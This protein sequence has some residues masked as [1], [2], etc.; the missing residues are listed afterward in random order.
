MRSINM[1][2]PKSLPDFMRLFPDDAACTA[3]LEDLR[4]PD[5]FTCA[6]CGTVGEPYRFAAFPGRL[7]CRSCKKTAYL[8]AG[9]VMERSHT[10]L[11]VW[12]WGAYLVSSLTPGM[13][14]VQFQRQLGLTRYETA[15]QI[16]H[17][18]R[19]GMVDA[20]RTKLGPRS[21]HVEV[22]ET[23]VGGRE[24]GTGR[25]VHN[26]IL[27]VGAIEAR[28]RAPKADAIDE[29]HNKATPKRGGLYAGRLRLSVIPSRQGKY[30]QEFVRG[31]VD[32]GA[33]VVTDGWRGYAK[34]VNEYEHIA[35]VEGDDDARV[36]EEYLPLIHLIFS[37][38]KAWLN[39]VHH[40]VGA[41]HLQAYLNEF[42]FRFNRRFLPFNAFKSLLGIGAE[43]ESPTYAE[44][45]S[46]T[47]LHPNQ[48]AV[49]KVNPEDVIK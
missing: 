14:A 40:G 9:T 4:W 15:F 11:S 32:E 45:Y 1:P 19:A 43:S 3:Y 38:L 28:R 44:L 6:Y 7:R 34:L 48:V 5:G 30:L 13:S 2:F 25:G 17:K 20:D 18:L 35:A 24:R 42:V 27:V 21:Q 47:W 10:P 36:A 46:K 16:L 22:D 23:W 26:K 39:G 37:N 33:T 49:P 8:Y 41:Q 31:N 12:F 29:R